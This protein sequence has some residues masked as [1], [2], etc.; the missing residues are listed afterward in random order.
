MWREPRNNT[1]NVSDDNVIETPAKG[2][3]AIILEEVG[4]GRG[5]GVVSVAVGVVT[6]NETENMENKLDIGGG[7]DKDGGG[8]KTKSSV[9]QDFGVPSCASL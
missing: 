9:N 7:Q 3:P 5:C 2:V 6:G 8:S 4:S 1:S